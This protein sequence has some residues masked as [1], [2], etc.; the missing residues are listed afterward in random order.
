MDEKKE[1]AAQEKNE[2]QKEHG[3][4]ECIAIRPAADVTDEY[5]GMEITFELPGVSA[6]NVTLEVKNRLLTLKAKST[7]HRR[8]MP[9]VYKRAFYLS[10]AV[11]ADNIS[12]KIS[13]G[14]LTLFLP[15]SE[16]AKTHRIP[17]E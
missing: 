3:K 12:A 6:E 5:D 17:V 13:D 15:K 16:C 11:D 9:V 4:C 14:I 10:D 1:P 7:L 2:L 8:G